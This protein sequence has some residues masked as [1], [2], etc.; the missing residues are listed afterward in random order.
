[1]TFDVMEVA[2]NFIQALNSCLV[3][4]YFDRRG[5][6]LES[7]GLCCSLSFFTLSFD[8]KLDFEREEVWLFDSE[9]LLK[10]QIVGQLFDLTFTCSICLSFRFFLIFFFVGRHGLE[11]CSCYL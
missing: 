11:K 4:L 1:M 7:S 9:V 5:S 3:E 10:V 2:I 6:E 8:F